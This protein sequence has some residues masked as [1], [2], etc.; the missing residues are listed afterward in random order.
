MRSVTPAQDPVVAEL[1]RLIAEY[2]WAVRHVG[3]DR[4]SGAAPFS[5]TVGLTALGHPEVVIT[6]M[7]FAHAQTFLN[8][9]GNDVRSGVR[10]DPGLV[11]E[12]LTGPGAP[13]T[14]LAVQDTRGLTAVEQ[15]YEQVQ[16][17]QMVWPDSVGRLPWQ[18]AYNN[19]PDAQPLL[20][21]RPS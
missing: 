5:Y 18:E 8:N 6:G 4:E 15:V 20:G 16:A 9:I 1:F 3:A 2:G 14:F 17:V 21:D 11:T 13:V 12:D 10:F 19:S 7:P